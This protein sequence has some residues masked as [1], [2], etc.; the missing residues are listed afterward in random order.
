MTTLELIFSIITGGSLL[1]WVTYL[2]TIRATKKKANAEASIAASDAAQK[3]FDAEK[4]IIENKVSIVNTLQ[5]AFDQQV[6]LHQE[7]KQELSQVC[8]H[9]ANYK[10]ELSLTKN[11]LDKHIISERNLQYEIDELKQKLD[12]VQRELDTL[13]AE[14]DVVKKKLSE[15]EKQKTKKIY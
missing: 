10:Q 5:E 4:D 1:A 9:I 12:E 15:Y 6:L 11:E 7:T 8:L 3:K 13:R 14:F 2:A